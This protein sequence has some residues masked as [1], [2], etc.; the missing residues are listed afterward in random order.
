M[1]G[2]GFYPSLY[3]TEWASVS[4]RWSAAVRDMI[5]V[6]FAMVMG[7]IC[8]TQLLRVKRWK[9][10]DLQCRMREYRQSYEE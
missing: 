7:T 4:K 5:D 2:V 3:G 9:S 10:E 1:A 6:S 8:H